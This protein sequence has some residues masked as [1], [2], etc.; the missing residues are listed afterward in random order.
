[1]ENKI[2]KE[3]SLVQQITLCTIACTMFLV[4]IILTNVEPGDSQEGSCFI[5]LH[6]IGLMIALLSVPVFDCIKDKREFLRNMK[7]LCN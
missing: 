5:W 1:M 3:Q 4:G 2:R 6:S 7:N